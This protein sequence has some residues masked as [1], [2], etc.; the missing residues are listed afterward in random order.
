MSTSIIEASIQQNEESR[1]RQRQEPGPHSK[2]QDNHSQGIF[3]DSGSQR[4]LRDHETSR[5]LSIDIQPEVGAVMTNSGD[6][7]TSSGAS[8]LMSLPILEQQQQSR[9][10]ATVVNNLSLN[11]WPID[12]QSGR[13]EISDQLQD[14]T[15]GDSGALRRNTDSFLNLGNEENESAARWQQ[16]NPWFPRN[17]FLSPEIPISPELDDDM[18]GIGMNSMSEDL[19]FDLLGSLGILTQSSIIPGQVTQ[20]S[21]FSTILNTPASTKSS[22][23]RISP[24]AVNLNS[25]QRPSVGSEVDVEEGKNLHDAVKA[26]LGVKQVANHGTHPTFGGNERSLS[27][28]FHK[29]HTDDDLIRMVRNYPSVMVR[30]GV[31]PPFVHHKLYRCAAGDIAEPLAKAFCCIGAFYAS[32]PTSETFVYSLINEESNKLVKG[33]VSLSR[34]TITRWRIY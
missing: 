5:N 11:T 20:P 10:Q 7:R 25:N 17:P 31:Y 16:D 6:R 26:S 19:N 30:P 9:L 23:L 15:F 34:P 13:N 24:N 28:P 2:H 29:L 33:F 12:L 3:S 22:D 14:A 27:C 1:E 32:V 4:V 8:N 21:P 18:H